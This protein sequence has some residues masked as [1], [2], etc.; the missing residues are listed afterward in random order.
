MNEHSNDTEVNC[1]Q[2]ECPRR[3]S[4]AAPQAVKP[5]GRPRPSVRCFGSGRNQEVQGFPCVRRWRV[6]S[7]GQSRGRRA[8]RPVFIRVLCLS[9]AGNALKK[10]KKHQFSSQGKYPD[11]S[12]RSSRALSSSVTATTGCG[13]MC[14]SFSPAFA[15]PCLFKGLP[16]CATIP[17]NCTE[18]DL[19]NKSSGNGQRS[20]RRSARRLAGLSCNLFRPAGGLRRPFGHLRDLQGRPLSTCLDHLRMRRFTPPFQT[21]F[22]PAHCVRDSRQCSW[23]QSLLMHVPR[24]F[25]WLHSPRCTRADSSSAVIHGDHPCMQIL[26]QEHIS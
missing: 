1:T 11:L 7:L 9:I 16:L 12:R 21:V 19:Q 26:T 15:I 3:A 5:T 4:E 24:H 14:P 8:T 18:R 6:W 13:R 22:A 2:R 10:K 23:S 20:I 25:R 17:N